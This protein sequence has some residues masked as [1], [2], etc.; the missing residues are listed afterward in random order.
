VV[1][2]TRRVPL[3]RLVRTDFRRTQ[4]IVRAVNEREPSQARTSSMAASNCSVAC[5]AGA[6]GFGVVG[7]CIEASEHVETPFCQCPEGFSGIDDWATYDDC[8]VDERARLAV[9]MLVLA[10]SILALIVSGTALRWLR[11]R[12]SFGSQRVARVSRLMSMTRVPTHHLAGL[13]STNGGGGDQSLDGRSQYSVN[14]A[15]LASQRKSILRTPRRRSGVMTRDN[16][17]DRK[18]RKQRNILLVLYL[19]V[20]FASTTVAAY[21]CLLLG[22]ADNIAY[23]VLVATFSPSMLAGMW[24]LGYTWYKSMPSVRMFGAMFA[25]S[26]ILS[27]Y[28]NLVLRALWTN[29]VLAYLT[30]HLLLW[31]LPL[32]FPQHR[33]AFQLAFLCVMAGFVLVYCIVLHLICSLLRSCFNQLDQGS[34]RRQSERRSVRFEGA[35]ADTAGNTSSRFSKAS[36]TINK[37]LR[38]NVLVGGSTIVLAIVTALLPQLHTNMYL[39]YSAP[40]LVASIYT[41]VNTM[42][43]LVRSGELSSSPRDRTSSGVDTRDVNSVGSQSKKPRRSSTSRRSVKRSSTRFRSSTRQREIPEDALA[44]IDLIGDDFGPGHKSSIVTEGFE[45]LPEDED[46]VVSLDRPISVRTFGGTDNDTSSRTS[47][48]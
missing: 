10:T 36:A 25:E 38:L 5:T 21:V 29:I 2:T 23:M 40:T 46:Y 41:V 43:F 45:F 35:S 20:L 17:A 47:S 6:A 24:M 14:S 28:P 34:S 13:R 18:W 30:S 31:V 4:V 7:S 22:L 37:T 15:P 12:W 39:V 3:L 48:D 19:Y 26:S 32:I 9:H 44:P 16:L 1:A 42:V 33:Q 8:H 27:R 11:S